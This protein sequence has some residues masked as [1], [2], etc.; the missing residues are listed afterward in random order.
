MLEVGFSECLILWVSICAPAQRPSGSCSFPTVQLEGSGHRTWTLA[1]SGRAAT[2]RLQVFSHWPWNTQ[3]PHR[4]SF[5]RNRARPGTLLPSIHAHAWGV[6]PAE[7][8]GQK[9]FQGP[10]RSF[11]LKDCSLLTGG[12][13]PADLCEP[14][15]FLNLQSSSIKP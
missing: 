8:Q 7:F 2:N 9:T 12:E 11:F 4:T 13:G 10:L 6:P 1:L 3:E 5:L 14:F 15:C